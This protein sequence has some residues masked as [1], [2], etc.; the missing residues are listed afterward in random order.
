MGLDMYLF[1]V[2][3]A[4]EGSGDQ[5]KYE[6]VAYWRKANQIHAWFVNNFQEGKDE[7][8][9]S[10]MITLDD[11]LDLRSLCQ[12]V[13]SF[14][15]NK[16]QPYYKWQDTAQIVLPSRSGFFFGGTEYDENYLYD[17]EL[18]VKQINE[19]EASHEAERHAYFYESSW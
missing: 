11:L 15:N 18:T 17:I 1:R 5:T 2:D 6:E 13:L 10:S 7:C 9:P 3:L 19:I 12:A 14:K 16:D 4:N 8:K